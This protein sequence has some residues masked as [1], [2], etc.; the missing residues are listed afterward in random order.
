MRFKVSHVDDGI[1]IGFV[2]ATQEASIMGPWWWEW[3]T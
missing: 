3:Q 2:I 1:A